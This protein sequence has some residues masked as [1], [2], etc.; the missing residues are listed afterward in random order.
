[1]H[2]STLGHQF[3]WIIVHYLLNEKLNVGVGE[4]VCQCACVCDSVGVCGCVWVCVGVCACVRVCACLSG[5]VCGR[6]RA[7]VRACVCVCVCVP[8]WA[9]VWARVR[10]CVC[11]CVCVCACVCVCVCPK[12]PRFKTQIYNQPIIKTVFSI[13]NIQHDIVSSITCFHS[14]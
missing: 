5:R 10:A 14:L 1:M 2:C 11:V 12:E 13:N 4:C 9:C 6:V 8:E 3:V 7:R